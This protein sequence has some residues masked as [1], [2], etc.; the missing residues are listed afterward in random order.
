M[1]TVADRILDHLAGVPNGLDDGQLADALGARRQTVN[2]ACRRLSD[3]G[4]LHRAPGAGG[5]I[6]NRVFNVTSAANG[7]VP[8]A[9]V[10]P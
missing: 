10:V 8:S 1:A 5:V 2:Q 3:Q 6:V 7:S 9:P 4:R